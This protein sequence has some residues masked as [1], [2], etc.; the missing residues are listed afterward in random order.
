M[1]S[2]EPIE[3]G[4]LNNGR[5]YDVDHILPRTFIKDDSLDNKVLV[6]RELNG[7]KK[8]EYPVP[9]G[10]VT[11]KAR[12]HWELLLKKE[13]ISKTTYD[14]LTRTEPLT[15]D[16][17]QGFIARQKVI[18][19]QTAKAVIELLQRKYPDTKIFFVKAKNVSDFKNDFK[20]FKCRETNDLH[21]ARDAYLNVVVGNVYYTTFN[22]PFGHH[23]KDGDKWREYNLKHLFDRNRKGAWKQDGD[24]SIKVVES[25]FKKHTMSVTRY[26]TCNKGEFYDAT[27]YKNT[28][29]SITAP[30]KEKGPLSDSSKYGGYKSQ[31]TAYFALVLSDGKKGE[32]IKTIE[33]IP[34]LTSLRAEKDP[35]AVEKY[36][37]TYLKNPVIVIPKIK[38]K[39]LVSYNGTLCYITGITGTRITANNAN[40]LYTDNKQDE[41]VRELGKLTDRVEKK[42][43]SPDQTEYV[44][45]T[46]KD[47]VRKLVITKEENE[48]LYTSLK[49]K[50]GEKIY[51]GIDAIKAF[52]RNLENGEETFKSLNVYEQSKVLLQILKFFKC[53][54]ETSDL[55]LIGGGKGVGKILFQKNITNADFKIINLSPAGL[56]KKIRKV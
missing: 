2:G 36:L 55:T 5:L 9:A 16:E 39:Q 40:Q 41:Y 21:H 18:T 35:Q 44:M 47:G 53:N 32:R 1:Y 50:L 15:D 20:L 51:K 34:V 7:K 3:I 52:K 4:D 6:R 46:N 56:T 29:D 43:D 23:Y 45:K 37:S 12:K 19:D 31:N 49:K 25:V 54:A 24:E 27:V 30:R 33:A 14:R 22:T 42:I 8:D 28:D 11:E 26:P 48:E 10:I 13:L 17:Y 38:N